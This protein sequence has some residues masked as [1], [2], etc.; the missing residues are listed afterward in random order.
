MVKGRLYLSEVANCEI[1]YSEGLPSQNEI[2]EKCLNLIVI[3]DLMNE[4]ASDVKLGNSFTKRCHHMNINVIFI[5]QNLFQQGKQ[6]RN[7]S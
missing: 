3:D 6:M 7:I 1:E 4:L 2:S 5:S